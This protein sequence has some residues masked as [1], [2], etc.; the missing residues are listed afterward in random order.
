MFIWKVYK[1]DIQLR[2]L[3]GNIVELDFLSYIKWFS[4]T[5]EHFENSYPQ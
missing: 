5:N 2:F 3:S 4:S 1:I